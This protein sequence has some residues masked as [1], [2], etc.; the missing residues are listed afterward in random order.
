[1]AGATG[2]VAAPTVA[3]DGF[4]MFPSTATDGPITK[5]HAYPGRPPVYSTLMIKGRCTAG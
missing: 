1:M 2:N 4:A 3:G 5:G